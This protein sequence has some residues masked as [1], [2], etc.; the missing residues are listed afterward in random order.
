[1]RFI[2]A[3]SIKQDIQ[4]LHR[5]RSQLVARRT[6]QANQIRGLL[7]E[8]GI[9]IPQGI[10]YIRKSLPDILEDGENRLSV[11][12]RE[13][14]SGLYNEMVHLDERIEALD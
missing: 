7:M 8:Y 5:I 12:F 9:V 2:P 6:A 11:L 4:S 3:K 10:S 14:F 13:Q 1:M